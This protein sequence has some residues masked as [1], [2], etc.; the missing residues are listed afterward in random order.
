MLLVLAITLYAQFKVKRVFKKYSRITNLKNLTGVQA[1]QTVLDKNNIPKIIINYINGEF[2]DN[3]NPVNNT[4]SLSSQVYS[5][6]SITAIG[7]AAHEAGHAVQNYT[8]YKL[9]KIRQKLVPVTQICSQFSMPLIIFGLILP[10]KYNFLVNIG[11]ILFSTA[12]IFQL[13][14]LPVEIDAS[15]RA[16]K[17][18]A[19]SGYLNN[20]ELCGVKEV[21]SAAG[22]TYL[23]LLF[24][25]LI[26]LIRLILIS[27]RRRD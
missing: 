18:L 12:V 24:T 20:Q 26:Y 7:V 13:I 15:R 9:L 22:M 17:S 8:R 6:N 21:L 16:L 1:A 2:N 10:V 25:S 23:A 11:I 14:T 27:S 19:S 3:F 5:S 4:I